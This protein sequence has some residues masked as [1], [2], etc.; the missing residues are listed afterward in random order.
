MFGEWIDW[1]DKAMRKIKH[2]SFT[3][4]VSAKLLLVGLLLVIG[5]VT[6]TFSQEADVFPIPKAYKIEGIPVIKN[7]EVKDLF[8]D[9]SAIKS[10]LIWD[11]DRKNRRLLVTDV[12]NNVY[13]LDTP[14]SQP[15]QLLQK[16]VPNL[17]KVRPDGT[18]FA[19]TSDQDVEDSYQLYLYD[20]KEKASKKLTN[21]TNKEHSVD[22]FIWS[23][24]GD[25]LFFVKVDYESK[26]TK[27]C[28]TDFQNEKCFEV[29]LGG[30]WE[31]VDNN[32]NKLLLKYWKASSNQYLYLFDIN[33]LL[34]NEFSEAYQFVN[35]II[36]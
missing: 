30:I 23:K 32:E 22:S 19:Y 25:S 5:T 20:F 4:T 27:L 3:K 14:M 36:Y 1:R 18:S 7:S 21:L 34:Y 16:F 26:T 2:K 17:V 9:S 28:Q 31:V 35:S 8:Y 10:N 12:K 6:S 29:K 33:N 11:S 15:V 13:L 24:K